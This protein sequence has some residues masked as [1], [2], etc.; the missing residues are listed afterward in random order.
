MLATAKTGHNM[1]SKNLIDIPQSRDAITFTWA[2]ILKDN[3]S[4]FMVDPDGFPNHDA[5]PTL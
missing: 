1:K 3:R 2:N 5:F 4:I